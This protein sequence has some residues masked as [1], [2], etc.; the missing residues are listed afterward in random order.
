[1]DALSVTASVI[2]LI[3]AAKTVY[4]IIQSIRH[5]DRGL[6]ALNKEISTLNGFLRSIESALDDCRG[7]AYA[8][9][10]IDPALWRESKVALSDCQ[11]TLDELASLFA[12]PKRPSRSN[13]LFRRARIAAELRSR[14]GQ[15]ASFREKISM[16]NLSLQTLL[17]VI[18]V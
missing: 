17:Q 5:A 11:K 14:A 4:N 12:E 1:M 9:T 3:E 16:S 2:T 7:N 18:N 8:L 6:Q 10:H 13:S 15:I